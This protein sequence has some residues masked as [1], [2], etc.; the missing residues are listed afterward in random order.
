MVGRLTVSAQ[1]MNIAVFDERARRML[2]LQSGFEDCCS[3]DAAT[4]YKQ[5]VSTRRAVDTNVN[6]RHDIL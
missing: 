4:T 1:N 6:G 2:R 3:L 5:H